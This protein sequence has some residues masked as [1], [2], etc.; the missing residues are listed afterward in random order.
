[1]PALNHRELLQQ[2]LAQLPPTLTSRTYS[3]KR[4]NTL[5]AQGCLRLCLPGTYVAEAD[6]K[7]FSDF[8]KDRIAQLAAA[9]PN[10]REHDVLSHSSAAYFW[11]IPDLSGD[12]SVHIF[13]A[14]H[15]NL[16]R[17][18]FAMHR[19]EI[20]AAHQ[21]LVGAIKLTSLERTA[22]D[23]GKQVRPELTLAALDYCLRIGASAETL[24]QIGAA[25]LGNGA[26]KVR[27][28]LPLAVP[29]SDSV[30]ESV[31]RYWAIAAGLYDVESQFD[32]IANGNR[33]FLD[34]AVESIKLAIEYDG[35]IKYEAPRALYNEKI[36]EDA[37]RADGWT[38]IRVVASDLRDP[39]RLVAKFRA[40]ASRLGYVF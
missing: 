34:L 2:Q 40:T 12:S 18:G 33:Y 26:A 16:D 7:G 15:R 21:V 35:A 10:L 28:L 19:G 11:G 27:R 32:V 37:L 1:M 36:R 5:Q 31:T 6:L 9:L 13:R 39:M 29:T 4:L 3:R 8:D 25:Q 17:K 20:P 23:L 30:P 14:P 22:I 38:V 24:S